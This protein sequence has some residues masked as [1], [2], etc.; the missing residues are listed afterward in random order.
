MSE[1]GKAHFFMLGEQHGTAD[2]ARAATALYLRLQ[3]LGYDRAAIE[4][5]PW[6]TPVMEKLMRDGD[7]YETYL[8]TEDRMLTFPFFFYTEEVEF[9]RAVLASSPVKSSALWGVDQEFV[10]GAAPVLDLLEEWADTPQARTAVARARAQLKENPMMLG[11]G[12][13][14]VWIDLQEAFLGSKSGEAL[15]LLEEVFVSRRI[16]APFVGGG[17]SVYL[18]NEERERYMK[19]NFM[20]HL[21]EAEAQLGETP[22]VY[23]KFGANH[24][25]Y[26]RSKTHVLSLGTFVREI[27]WARGLEVFNVHADCIGGQTRDPR[28]GE[29]PPC[30]SYLVKGDSSLM[31]HL[32]EDRIT[33]IDLRSLRPYAKAWK[34]FDAESKRL[35]WSFDAYLAIP[36]P[37]AAGVVGQ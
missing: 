34:D 7:A 17:G 29:T 24:V 5:G 37:K 9:A 3:P 16:Y 32:I 25:F 2:I 20:R 36:E 27:A 21:T 4:V 23:L 6:S 14:A 11:S 30:S 33:L 8:A 1:A 28:S 12:D 15:R 26:G 18:A 35:I 13:D 19:T 31:N 22:R 10:A